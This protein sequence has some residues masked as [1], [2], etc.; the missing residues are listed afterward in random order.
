ML[1]E[2]DDVGGADE[3]PDPVPPFLDDTITEV[4]EV[5]SFCCCCLLVG[6]VV[7]V[8][9]FFEFTVFEQFDA[10]ETVTP[11]VELRIDF[12]IFELLGCFVNGFCGVVV[13]DDNGFSKGVAIIVNP[14]FNLSKIEIPWL[15]AIFVFFFFFCFFFYL[16]FQNTIFG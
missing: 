6:G 10:K 7:A 12:S 3:L 1:E 16:F 11:E 4:I 5:S 8:V 9:V 15:S 2:V 14:C 13:V